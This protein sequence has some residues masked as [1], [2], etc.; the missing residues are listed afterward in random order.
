MAAT[1]AEGW[2][3]Q[4]VGEAVLNEPPRALSHLQNWQ[5]DTQ[6]FLQLH[7]V[8]T[9]AQLA[10]VEDLAQHATLL[11]F[12]E[13]LCG[14]GFRLDLPCRPLGEAYESGRMLGGDSRTRDPARVRSPLAAS[15]LAPTRWR[16]DSR[17]RGWAGAGVFPYR[18]GVHPA[19]R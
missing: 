13:D 1:R 8:A 18:R 9:A 4:L 7:S 3:E 19:A 14:D 6:G 16:P 11:A 2:A 15:C 5:F 12:A 10:S 17:W